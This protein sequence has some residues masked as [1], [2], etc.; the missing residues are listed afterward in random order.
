MFCKKKIPKVVQEEVS[1]IKALPHRSG[2][3]GKLQQM[4]A[5]FAK[6]GWNHNL[7]KS[8]EE[9]DMHRSQQNKAKAYPR[10][11]MVTTCRGEKGFE[12]AIMPF[13]YVCMS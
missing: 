8:I 7:F 10:Q 4:A 3:Q 11:V 6:P 12:K 9:L 2:K 5:A 1:N 13:I